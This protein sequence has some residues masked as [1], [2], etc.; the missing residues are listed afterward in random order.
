[1]LFYLLLMAQI[2][3]FIHM[4]STTISEQRIKLQLANAT[5]PT[6]IISN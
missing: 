3:D 5:V 1:M 2:R 6:E 4:K